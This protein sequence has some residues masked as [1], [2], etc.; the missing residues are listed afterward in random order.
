[1]TE[2][3]DGEVR[4]KVV[5]GTLKGKG[6]ELATF[7]EPRIGTRPELSGD[8]IE[9]D[10]ASVR[11]GVKPRH[12]KTYIKRFLYM[13]GVRKSYRVFVTGK[14]LMVQEIE[15][16]EKKEEEGEEKEKKAPEKKEEAEEAKP[17]EPG[18][19]KAEEEPPKE[20][21]AEEKPKAKK[22]APRKPRAAK[23]KAAAEE[24]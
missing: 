14:E 20:E 23:K 1:M 5:L 13:N 9:I 16:G 10:D 18:A 15:L 11:A 17:E 6:E 4:L 24:S 2:P 21:A 19:P 12:V 3:P 7:L 22:G 8:S